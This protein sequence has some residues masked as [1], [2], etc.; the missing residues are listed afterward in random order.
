MVATQL[1]QRHPVYWLYFG[2]EDMTVEGTNAQQE[3]ALKLFQPVSTQ[4]LRFFFHCT[5]GLY[6]FGYL[7]NGAYCTSQKLRRRNCR[8]TFLSSSS[9]LLT[10]WLLARADWWVFLARKKCLEKWRV[11]LIWRASDQRIFAAIGF[12]IKY[13]LIFNIF[14]LF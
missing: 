6:I 5:S 14:E 2:L 8:K 1:L 9:Q 4:K 11:C 3:A 13:W 12:S 7:S 10:S